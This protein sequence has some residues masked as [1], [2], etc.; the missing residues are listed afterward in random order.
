[1]LGSFLKKIEPYVGFIEWGAR[2]LFTGGAG[3]MAGWTAAA[4]KTLTEYAPLSYVLAGLAGALFAALFLAAWAGFR[5]LIAKVRYLAQ[6]ERKV[7]SINPLEDLFNK[8]RIDM[9][10]F[11]N[12]MNQPA[13]NKS[14]VDCELYGPVVVFFQGHSI[15]V[16]S[17]I[18]NCDFVK[19]R[20][21]VP[22]HSVT[23]FNNISIRRCKLFRLTILVPEGAADQIPASAHWIT[24]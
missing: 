13:I 22:V 21:G 8:R 3:L 14:F 24:V 15:L 7:D 20:E 10:G 16:D 2:A 19:V 23:V 9:Q 4:T 6:F 18:T 12:P 5:S 11:R 17:Q 1:M